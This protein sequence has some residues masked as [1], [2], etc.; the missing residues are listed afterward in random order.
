MEDSN[1][2]I[3]SSGNDINIFSADTGENLDQR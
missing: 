1:L 2:K 3:A